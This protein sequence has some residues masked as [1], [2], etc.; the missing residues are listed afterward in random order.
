MSGSASSGAVDRTGVA[1]PTRSVRLTRPIRLKGL[2]SLVRRWP[3]APIAVVGFVWMF[4]LAVSS[5]QWFFADEWDFIATRSRPPLSSAASVADMLLTPHNEHWSTLPILIYRAVFGLVGLRAYWPYLVVLYTF[6]AVVIVLIVRLLRRHG[7]SAATRCFAVGMFVVYGAGAEN[8][9]WAFQFA[10]MAA[11]IAGLLV[12][13][14]VDVPVERC[15]R[16]RVALAW[17]VG[18][19]GL[20]CAG[21]G[22]SMVAAGVFTAWLRWGWRRAFVVASVPAAVQVLWTVAYGR[23]SSPTNTPATTIPHRAVG[24][25]W[26]ALSTTI[27]RTVGLPGVGPLV[28]VGLIVVVVRSF[29]ELRASDAALLGLAAA[30]VPFLGLVAVGRIDVDNPNASRYSYVLFVL[31]APLV[32]VLIDRLVRAQ[33]EHDRAT[34]GRVIPWSK[35]AAAVGA[36]AVITSVGSLADAADREGVVERQTKRTIVAAFA[37]ARSNFAAA[38]AIPDPQS[39]DL[40]I[41]GVRNLLRQGEAPTGPVDRQSLATVLAQSSVDVTP[42]PRIPL[43]GRSITIAS[44]GRMTAAPV[45]SGCVG[46]FPQGPN[47]QVSLLP[48]RPASIKIVPLVDGT[49]GIVVRRDGR[50]A[51][52]RPIAVVANNPVFVNLADPRNE[53]VLSFPTDGQTKACGIGQVLPGG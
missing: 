52:A 8:L 48:R 10:W 15:T 41:A 4:W 6:H 28:L 9:L 13:E 5:G 53:Y 27:D 26:R 17:V 23:N 33:M 3:E 16:S 22:V 12:V 38:N 2:V 37:V 50:S 19:A 18:V 49:L 21:V 51:E 11:C 35:L 32:F 43:D 39:G 29:P 47:P 40:T 30:C 25:A 46:F 1:G 14:I 31:L 7:A 44:L 20:M 42:E 34:G 24:Y 45:E 36:L